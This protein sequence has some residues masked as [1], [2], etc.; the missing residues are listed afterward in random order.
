[1]H[2]ARTRELLAAVALAIAPLT[3]LAQQPSVLEDGRGNTTTIRRNQPTPDPNP[4][5]INL[6]FPGGDFSAFVEAL[7]TAAEAGPVNVV[8]PATAQHLDVPPLELRNVTVAGALRSLELVF[9]DD[10]PY[11]IAVREIDPHGP[12]F[13]V[14]VARMNPFGGRSAPQQQTLDVISITDFLKKDDHPGGIPAD[15]LLD[16]LQTTLQMSPTN[17]NGEDEAPPPEIRFHEE[18]GLLIV[19]GLPQEV[20]VVRRVLDELRG[21]ITTDTKRS[22]VGQRAQARADYL[23]RKAELEVK[24]AEE[25]L[26]LATKTFDRVKSLHEQAH[27]PDHEL[28]AADDRR[29]QANNNLAKAI[30]EAEYIAVTSAETLTDGTSEALK[31]L[32]SENDQLRKQLAMLQQ[33]LASMQQQQHNSGRK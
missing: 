19:R 26:V 20:S 2:H 15:I 12:V 25:Q 17:S 28:V 4:R 23:K 29:S 14:E 6:S 31:H 5:I 32:Q 18:A 22:Q 8:M 24:A 30:L 7:R 27:A 21:S 16:S 1:M 9:G 3:T 13:G 11:R 10:S 33:T